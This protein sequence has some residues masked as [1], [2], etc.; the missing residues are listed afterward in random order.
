M[1]SRRLAVGLIVPGALVLLVA[2]LAT[3]QYKW[4]G[5]VSNAE[6]DQKRASLHQNAEDLAD[7]FDREMTRAYVAFQQTDGTALMQQD[8]SA[9]ATRY[10][11]W[12]ESAKDPQMVK[13]VYLATDDGT[14]KSFFRY[15]PETRAFEPAGW[16]DV[17]A[18]VRASLNGERR[19]VTIPGMGFRPLGADGPAGDLPSTTRTVL[20]LHEPVFPSV[21]ALLISLPAFGPL[22]AF[23]VNEPSGVF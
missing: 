17:L 16:P 8:W 6:R 10:D 5:Q 22:Q 15:M 3:L 19:S 1:R 7:D 9:F 23:T 18:P 12:R 2:L 4:L 21:P 20:A 14:G 11:V 13:A